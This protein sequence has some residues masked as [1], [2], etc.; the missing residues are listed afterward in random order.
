MKFLWEDIQE[1]EVSRK[2][3]INFNRNEISIPYKHLQFSFGSDEPIYNLWARLFEFER[4]IMEGKP[5]REE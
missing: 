5:M 4:N 1:A 2:Q 3:V